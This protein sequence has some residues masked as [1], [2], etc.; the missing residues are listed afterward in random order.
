MRNRP[1]HIKDK[2]DELYYEVQ[3]KPDPAQQ[4]QTWKIK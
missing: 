1:E 4:L 2:L 3:K